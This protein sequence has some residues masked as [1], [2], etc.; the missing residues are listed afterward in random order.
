MTWFGGWATPWPLEWGGG[1]GL[2]EKIYTALRASVG[3]GHAADVDGIERRT[4][5]VEAIGL[6]VGAAAIEQAFYQFEPKTAGAGLTYYRELFDLPEGI[7]NQEA[8]ER[9][10]F[11][12][13]D[14]G[15]LDIP[16]VLARLRT[17]DERFQV[18]LVPSKLTVETRVGNRAFE[19]WSG[20]PPFNLWGRRDTQ[21]SNHSTAFR[22]LVTLEVDHVGEVEQ[23]TIDEATRYLREGIAWGGFTIATGFGFLL[24]RSPL[25]RTRL[26]V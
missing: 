9:A 3:K 10:A 17:I 14:Q 8:R 20:A 2:V 1:P 21:F 7:S 18:K 25:G 15:G 12:F 22:L 5:Q 24:G 19:P 23:R 26:S 16:T 13:H 11:L 6:A 4:R